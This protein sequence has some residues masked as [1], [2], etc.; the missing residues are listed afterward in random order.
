M[1]SLQIIPNFQSSQFVDKNG[2]LMPNWQITLNQLF[3]Q[4][5]SYLSNE[6]LKVPQQTTANI[7]TLNT[8]KSIGVLLYDSNANE[9]KVNINGVFKT[10]TTS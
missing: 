8:D 3:N 4:L 6:G 9:L 7:N 10:I 5:Q 2:N 1:T